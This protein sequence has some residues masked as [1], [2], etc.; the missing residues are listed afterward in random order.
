MQTAQRNHG[1]SNVKWKAK[2]KVT[3]HCCANY[4]LKLVAIELVSMTKCESE[5]IIKRA[6]HGCCGIFPRYCFNVLLMWTMK[7]QLRRHK[8]QRSTDMF[9]LFNNINYDSSS[10]K[11]IDLFNFPIIFPPKFFNHLNQPETL[12]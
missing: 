6:Y 10:V 12:Q 2:P 1:I 3:V 8:S 4:K 11:Q 9:V 7:Q 5:S